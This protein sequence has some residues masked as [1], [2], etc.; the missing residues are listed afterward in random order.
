MTNKHLYSTIDEAIRTKRFI[1]GLGILKKDGSIVRI[2]GQIFSR[3]TTKSGEEVVTIDNFFGRS[4][5][6]EKKRW[7]MVLVK[8][9]IALNSDHWRMARAA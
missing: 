1:G 8:N 7:Q 4:R 5:R 6:G 9:L 2:N 3:H